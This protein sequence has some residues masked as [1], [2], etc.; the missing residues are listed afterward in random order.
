AS[1][2]M[3]MNRK[4]RRAAQKQAPASDPIR[5]LLASA[6]LAQQ[7][8]ELTEAIRHYK[9]L[10]ALAPDHAEAHNN[11]ATILLDQGKRAEA[12][13][14]FAHSLSLVPQLFD[15]FAHILA[16]LVELLPALAPALQ[17]AAGAWPQRLPPDQLLDGGIDAI[18][19]DA[20]LLCALETAPI[21]DLAVERLLTSL[22]ASLLTAATQAQAVS[23][24]VLA[25]ACAL[26]KQCFINEYVFATTP[27]EEAAVETLKADLDAGAE[28]APLA[29]AAIAM[30]EPL[31]ALKTAVLARRW[32]AA[33]DGLI[34]QQVREVE[35]ERALRDTIPRL[36][37][38]EDDVSQ[39]VR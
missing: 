15:R 27:A 25:F 5:Q 36:T 6:A 12:S 13:P 20:L 26:A 16:V 35:A 3:V 28:V 17:R 22:R 9:R 29:L 1:Y 30:Y 8:N 31:H 24:P 7:R 23:E 10:I 32:P 14:H 38:I 11:L 4:Q 18:A 21:R 2:T 33:L 34:A 39:A 19:S 37:P